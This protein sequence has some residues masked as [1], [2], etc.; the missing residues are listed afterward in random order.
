MDLHWYASA[1]DFA[2]DILLADFALHDYGMV[3]IDRSGTGVGVEVER[4]ILG[5]TELHAAG[6]GVDHPTAGGLA[7]DLD[8]AATGLGLQRTVHVVQL[9]PA[10]TV[11]RPH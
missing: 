2:A 11:G 5:K 1:A 6:T 8:I 10:R 4:G 9:K 7:L 3:Q